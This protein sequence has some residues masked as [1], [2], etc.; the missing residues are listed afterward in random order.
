[1][2]EKD[3]DEMSIGELGKAGAEGNGSLRQLGEQVDARLRSTDVN[4][5]ILTAMLREKIDREALSR[6]KCD[7]PWAIKGAIEDSQAKDWEQIWESLKAKFRQEIAKELTPEQLQQFRVEE[8]LS[9]LPQTLEDFVLAAVRTYQKE[10]FDPLATF[11]RRL[12]LKNA[13]P[14]TI[15]NDRCI[16][17]AFVAKHGRKRRCTNEEI[18]AFLFGSKKRLMPMSYYTYWTVLKSFLNSLPDGG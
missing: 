3:F 9:K 5:K 8:F 15:N 7:E 4:L 1:M 14:G 18:E 11:S 16:V 17:A 10:T 6:Y 12:A 2:A 13:R